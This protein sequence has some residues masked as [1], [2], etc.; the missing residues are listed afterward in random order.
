MRKR[1]YHMWALFNFDRPP[2]FVELTRRE[3]IVQGVNWLGGENELR[4][5]RRS[6][7]ITIEKIVLRRVERTTKT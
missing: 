7:S 6:G 5:H 2:I 3:C 4:K 1:T